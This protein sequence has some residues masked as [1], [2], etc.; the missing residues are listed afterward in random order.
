VIERISL[1]LALAVLLVPACRSAAGSQSS[2]AAIPTLEEPCALLSRGEIE[3]VTGSPVVRVHHPISKKT[4]KPMKDACAYEAD[5]PYGAII[6][7]LDVDGERAFHR[8]VRELVADPHQVVEIVRGVGDEAYLIGRT[9]LMVLESG[10][11]FTVGT[12]YYPPDGPAV[13]RQLATLALDR[14][15]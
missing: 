14:W 13:L 15:P 9:H 12:Q 8:E 6:V 10:D 7:S 11:V 4:V 3:D 1:P 5:R 2:P